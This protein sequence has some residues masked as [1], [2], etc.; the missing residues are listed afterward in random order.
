MLH[1]P[2][3]CVT[4][5]CILQDPSSSSEPAAAAAAAPPA[6]AVAG[7]NAHGFTEPELRQLWDSVSRSLLKLGKSGL[8]DTHI[9]SLRELLLSHKLVKVQ[10][11]AAKD[12]A[13]VAAAAAD[14][15][16]RAS[17]AGILLQVGFG[18][19]IEPVGPA[20][21][22]RYTVQDDVSAVNRQAFPYC[23]RPVLR[24]CVFE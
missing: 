9:N 1:L 13:G 5:C 15:A 2:L 12:D 18:K 6:A 7:S 14:V 16:Q 3:P 17:E 22:V 19:G 10:L 8:S 21:G 11:N 24:G 20:G 4:P 23:G